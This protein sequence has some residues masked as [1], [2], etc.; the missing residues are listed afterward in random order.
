LVETK[1]AKS[2][3]DAT[4]VEQDSNVAKTVEDDSKEEAAK[5]QEDKPVKDV[6]S[7][8]SVK[9]GEDGDENEDGDEAEPKPARTLSEGW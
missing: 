2:T 3:E 9:D 8:S 6:D 7:H 1:T 4:N 5:P